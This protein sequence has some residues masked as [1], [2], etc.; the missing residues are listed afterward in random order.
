MKHLL[1][2]E[3]GLMQYDEEGNAKIRCYNAIQSDGIINIPS[4]DKYGVISKYI[5]MS[6]AV[7]VGYLLC[8]SECFLIDANVFRTRYANGN[9]KIILF[10]DGNLEKIDAKSWIAGNGWWCEVVSKDETTAVNWLIED[11]T[12]GVLIVR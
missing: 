6:V 9:M 11:K 5:G 12:Q 4:K 7:N 8:T 2:T 3:N 1:I 10:D